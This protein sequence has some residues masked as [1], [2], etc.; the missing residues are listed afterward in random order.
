M[1]A[2]FIALAALGVQGQV[3]DR[4]LL[5]EDGAYVFL[6]PVLVC[7]GRSH[8]PTWSDDG[9]FLLVAADGAHVTPRDYKQWL[10][11]NPP[12]HKMEQ[13]Q[14]LYVYS[15][16]SGNVKELWSGPADSTPPGVCISFFAN[17]DVAIAILP[18]G[19]VLRVT[20][21]TSKIEKI[22]TLDEPGWLFPDPAGKYVAVAT[23]KSI[24]FVTPA[25]KPMA[26]QL[27]PGTEGRIGWAKD[28]VPFVMRNRKAIRLVPGGD[29][30]ELDQTPEA[31]FP[32]EPTAQIEAGEFQLPVSLNK[33][34]IG[35][36][37]AQIPGNE[38]AV[39]V[40]YNILNSDKSPADTGV[41]YQTSNY[42]YVRPVIK[43]SKSAYDK[44]IAEEERSSVMKDIAQI[45]VALLM[46]SADNDDRFPTKQEYD[47]GALD[48]YL[49][50]SAMT[51][52]FVYLGGKP[53]DDPAGTPL[54]YRQISGGRV[55]LYQ[56]GH[57]VFERS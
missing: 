15:Q 34:K 37:A 32:P 9:E 46:Y 44:M 10:E 29:P 4:A 22:E 31:V 48:P 12:T 25:E 42:A 38:H 2:G 3:A 39:I 50:N 20:A 6:D 7:E 18:P 51:Q 30:I 21:G 53:A 35:V 17:S 56:D 45:G 36:V 8:F 57:V 19:L 14:H 27:N 23:M 43:I 40:A 47:G 33:S 52:G 41:F 55:V 26:R 11:G 5:A 28:S 49:Q 13:L 24:R 1:I 54:G 16:R